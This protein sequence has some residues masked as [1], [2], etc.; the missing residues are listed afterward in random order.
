MD[1]EVN[2][3]I[4]KSQPLVPILSQ[5]NTLHSLPTDFFNL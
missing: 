2:Y 3:H 1:H 5:I 4:D